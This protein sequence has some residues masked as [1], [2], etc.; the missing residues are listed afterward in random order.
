MMNGRQKLFSRK[1][2]KT[3]AF[4]DSEKL[5]E[6]LE[7]HYGRERA[8]AAARSRFRSAPQGG[9]RM[10]LT[11][12]EVGA[13]IGEI[14]TGLSIVVLIL[15]FRNELKSQRLQSLLYLHQYLAQDDLSAARRAVRTRLFKVPYGEWTDD[16]KIIANRVCASYD[17][18]GILITS[19]A[20]D[21]KYAQALLSSSWGESICDQYEALAHFLDHQQT[22][23]KTGREFFRSFSDLYKM[24]RV[25]HRTDGTKNAR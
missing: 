7:R 18:A 22:P 5:F 11:W 10:D 12:L 17:Q 3:S 14:I 8:N 20:I 23:R 13:Q 16:D 9:Y 15:S 6:D 2:G 19:G 25:Y 4:F 24:A 1:S 21:S